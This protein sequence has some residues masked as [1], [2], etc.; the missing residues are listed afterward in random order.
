MVDWLV[1]KDL[2]TKFFHMSTMVRRNWNS[3]VTLQPED[4]SWLTGRKAISDS[5]VSYLA[6]FLGPYWILFLLV[7]RLWESLNLWGPQKL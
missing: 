1:S 6:N 4:H 7:M 3:I 2:N 5:L